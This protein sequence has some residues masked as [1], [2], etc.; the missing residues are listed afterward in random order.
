M[1]LK[2]FIK[3]LYWKLKDI[4]KYFVKIYTK[5]F[6]KNYKY[7]KPYF[8]DSDLR[9]NLEKLIDKK[10]ISSFL[11][12][13]SFEGLASIWINKKFLHPKGKH[14]IVDPF[15]DINDTTTYVDELVENNFKYNLAKI[16]KD[17]LQFFR[18][19][20]DQFFKENTSMYD[21][22]Y[23]DGSHLLEDIEK[24]LENSDK[25]LLENGIIWCD[26]Y[27]GGDYPNECKIAYDKFYEKNKHKYDVLFKNYQIAYR[28]KFTNQQ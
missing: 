2:I 11:E 22:I 16:K 9:Y 14:I 18:I 27:L 4:K 1:K 13:G 17:N 26:D 10:S 5:Y 12:I 28:K 15:T 6:F 24:D 23:I 21:F 20:S 3:S 25:Y 19:T 7:S 8:L